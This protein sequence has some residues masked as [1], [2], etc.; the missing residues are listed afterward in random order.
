MGRAPRPWGR[1]H[2]LIRPK[3]HCHRDR[4]CPTVNPRQMSVR[5]SASFLR[6]RSGRRVFALAAAVLAIML[7]P[8]PAQAR[9]SDEVRV[10]GTCGRGATSSLRLSSHDRTIRIRFRVDSNRDH[11]RWRVVLVRE[12]R[13]VWR[14][15]VRADGGGSFTVV[16]RARDLRGADEVTAR[17]VGPRGLTCI[18][19][20]T[21]RS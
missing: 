15:H 11:S 20:A 1:P 7:A 10:A 3:S 17:A 19:R 4:H 13:I 9:G 6:A 5:A 16:R 18:A 14:G 12:G 21:L 8:S 2:G